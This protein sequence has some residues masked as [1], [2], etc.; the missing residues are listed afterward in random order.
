MKRYITDEMFNQLEYV[1][2]GDVMVAEKELCAMLQSFISNKDHLGVEDTLFTFC[3]MLEREYFYVGFMEGIRFLLRV[4]NGG[5]TE[6][7]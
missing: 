7:K 4:C 2:S 1:N 6:V 3:S 5:S